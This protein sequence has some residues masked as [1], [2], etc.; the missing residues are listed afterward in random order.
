V[1]VN[2]TD[3]PDNSSA[4]PSCISRL[5]AL[6]T[7]RETSRGALEAVRSGQATEKLAITILALELRTDMIKLRTDLSHSGGGWRG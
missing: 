2:V 3:T 1:F 4:R 5:E 7:P 6:P